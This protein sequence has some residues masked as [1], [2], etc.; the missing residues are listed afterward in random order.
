MQVVKHLL[1]S[2]FR[3]LDINIKNSEGLTAAE[4]IEPQNADRKVKNDNK[5]NYLSRKRNIVELT[6][7]RLARSKKNISLD[8]LSAILVITALVITATYQSSLSP[9]GGVW[10]GGDNG[11]NNPPSTAGETIS[12]P[13]GIGFDTGTQQVPGTTVMFPQPFFVFWFWNTLTIWVTIF[14]TSWLLPS[15]PFLS[16][17]LMPLY[18]LGACYQYSMSVISPYAV[19]SSINFYMAIVIPFVP[20]V[21][22]YANLI[23]RG[24]KIQAGQK[25]KHHLLK[26]LQSQTKTQLRE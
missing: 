7:V 3:I 5:S 18:F 13:Q 1:G 19:L 17:I 8:L 14:L 23:R 10:Q 24:L 12:I 21:L 26:I 11:S 15:V 6:S 20:L 2:F 25:E 22:M 9:P 16:V 4:I